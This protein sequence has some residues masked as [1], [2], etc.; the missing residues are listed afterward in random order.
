MREV[1]D[2]LIKANHRLDR[3]RA[4]A[5]ERRLTDALGQ[6]LA[7]NERLARWVRTDVVHAPVLRGVVG[8]A[9]ELRDACQDIEAWAGCEE[10]A[11]AELRGRAEA[12][13]PD[14]AESGARFNTLHEHPSGIGRVLES[15][16]RLTVAGE[17]ALPRGGQP[18]HARAEF[19]FDPAS[20]LY[21]SA[22]LAAGVVLC[23][24]IVLLRQPNSMA[25]PRPLADLSAP[26]LPPALRWDPPAMASPRAVP[27][28]PPVVTPPQPLPP[29]NMSL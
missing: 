26:T 12:P 6:G 9:E 23:L 25:Y 22:S 1:V 4:I 28:A 21:G 13:P 15:A 10:R 8:L 19:P 7:F 11:R 14:E 29:E 27:P 24:A 2:A 16:R 20:F 18:L 3:E 5:Q 17:N